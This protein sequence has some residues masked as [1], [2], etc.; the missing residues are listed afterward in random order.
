VK[1]YGKNRRKERISS[2]TTAADRGIYAA[3]AA[4]IALKFHGIF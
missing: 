4:A 3:A 2:T 1:R